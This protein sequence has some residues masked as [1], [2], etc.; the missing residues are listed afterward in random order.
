[1]KKR[2]KTNC[3]S[4]AQQRAGGSRWE[5]YAAQINAPHQRETSEKSVFR[6][7]S[8]R[9]RSGA[10]DPKKRRVLNN[11]GV[12]RMQLKEEREKNENHDGEKIEGLERRRRRKREPGDKSFSFSPNDCETV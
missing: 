11:S 8:R 2:K 3:R 7:G 4:E 9:G 5:L 12:R 1:M 10:K 6:P